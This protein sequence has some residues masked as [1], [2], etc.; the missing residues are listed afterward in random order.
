MKICVSGACGFIGGELIKEL[1]SI[2]YDIVAIDDGEVYKNH[3]KIIGHEPFKEFYDWKDIYERKTDFLDDVYFT[4][5]L[6]ANSSTRA[7]WEELEIINLQFSMWFIT[8]N[9]LKGI[10]I[11]VASSGAV[12]GSIRK[13]AS[14]LE[15]LTNYGNSKAKVDRFVTF[16][17][18]SD[19]VCL[20]YHNVYGAT[21]SHKGNM[22]S[23]V[24]KWVDNY[25]Q[26]I[27]TND[28]FY[29]SDKIKRDFIHV[30]DVTKINIMFLLFYNKHKKL[31][32]KNIYDVGVG[33]ATSFESVAKHIIKHTKGTIQYTINPYDE[34]SYQF[35]TK[36]DIKDICEI[37]NWV[38][39]KNF[40]PMPIAV[41]VKM[42]FHQ[43]TYLW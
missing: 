24:S 1:K 22:A 3:C 34:K 41:G 36:A 11:V 16:L 30:D 8:S 29:G 20:R 27:L 19:V 39:D 9:N 13:V 31:P 15:P 38:H 32:E 28:L 4:Y 23:I 25:K 42:V 43:K 5:H 33:R 2:G 40:R 26:G 12:Y 17:K 14:K 37:Y 21:E 10:P 35:Y 7:T 6:G 18:L